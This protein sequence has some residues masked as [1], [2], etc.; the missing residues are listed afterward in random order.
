MLYQSPFFNKVSG[1]KPFFQVWENPFHKTLLGDC[2]WFSQDIL[3][4]SCV[5]VKENWNILYIWC[6]A[7]SFIIFENYQLKIT[8]NRNVPCLLKVAA[9]LFQALTYFISWT[10]NNS[11]YNGSLCLHD[12]TKM[13]GSNRKRHLFGVVKLKWFLL[14]NGIN[15]SGKW[16]KQNFY[17]YARTK[18]SDVAV[19]FG[20]HSV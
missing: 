4:R 20:S 14:F 13:I 9:N 2:S 11:C 15:I 18:K 19:T 5:F 12:H 8:L 17:A 1:L 16:S 7:F 3:Y 10:V 6:K